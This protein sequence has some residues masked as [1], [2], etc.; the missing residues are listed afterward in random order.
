MRR[1]PRLSRRWWVAG[2]AAGVAGLT[3]VTVLGLGPAALAATL[4]SD[5]F[6]SGAASSWSKSGGTW[7]VVSDGSQVLQESSSTSDLARDFN[8][9]TSWTDYSL[10]ASVKPLA[11]GS[12]D[13]LVGIA[14]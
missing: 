3:A 14:A 6:E 9:T 8:G 4:F 7:S 1:A 13:G 12:S 5:N 2:M 11:Y 10:Q